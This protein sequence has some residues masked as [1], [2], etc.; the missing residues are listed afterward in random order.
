MRVLLI[1][2]ISIIYIIISVESKIYSSLDIYNYEHSNRPVNQI[3]NKPLRRVGKGD[4]NIYNN[5]R[6]TILDVNLLYNDRVKAVYTRGG[7]TKVKN[8]GKR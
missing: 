4:E 2:S 6:S 5:E 3:N 1:I 7:A 8:K